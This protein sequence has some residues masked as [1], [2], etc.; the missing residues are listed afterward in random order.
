MPNKS[1]P[2]SG[3]GGRRRA[4]AIDATVQKMAGNPPEKKEKTVQK[5]VT[6]PGSYA[7]R[8]TK[9]KAYGAPLGTQ[10]ERNAARSR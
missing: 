1:N 8:K 3:T 6:L 7:P 5:P 9:K 10:N 4:A 2:G